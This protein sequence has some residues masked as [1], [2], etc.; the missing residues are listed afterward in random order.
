MGGGSGEAHPAALRLG[1]ASLDRLAQCPA[2]GFNAPS[3]GDRRGGVGVGPVAATGAGL[4]GVSNRHLDQLATAICPLIGQHGPHRQRHVVFVTKSRRRVLTKAVLDHVRTIF[5]SVCADFGAER[6]EREG[7]D[8]HGHRLVTSPPRGGDLDPGEQPHGHVEPPPAP[9]PPA[10]LRRCWQGAV[11]ARLSHLRRRA[12]RHPPPV[13][14]PAPHARLNL[15]S[16]QTRLRADLRPER[17]SVRRCTPGQGGFLLKRRG[18]R[19]GMR[20]VPVSAHSPDPPAFRP[21]A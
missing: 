4:T 8:D 5:A 20:R 6:V 9:A 16:A 10:L 2:T 18:S 11:V 14:R 1:P 7:D 12:A 21:T 19:P 13:H 17:R 15:M 3:D